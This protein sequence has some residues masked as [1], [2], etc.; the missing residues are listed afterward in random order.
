MQI[1]QDLSFS[2]FHSGKL[3]LITQLV[4]RRVAHAHGPFKAGFFFL[5]G[6]QLLNLL[7]SLCLSAGTGKHCVLFTGLV[8]I[9][10]CFVSLVLRHTCSG[11]CRKNY[12]TA[13]ITF[14]KCHIRR[15]YMSISYE[16]LTSVF[17]KFNG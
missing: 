1:I 6:L 8:F 2:P 17:I 9:W 5:A 10:S 16:Q 7:T 11:N 12:F 3:D 4:E 15:S 13:M 14:N